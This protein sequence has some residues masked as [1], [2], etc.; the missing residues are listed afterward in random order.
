MAVTMAVY[1]RMSGMLQESLCTV[2]GV[3]QRGWTMLRSNFDWRNSAGIKREE[4]EVSNQEKRGECRGEESIE[5]ES[6]ERIRGWRGIRRK[7]AIKGKADAEYA[8]D[9]T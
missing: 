7:G 3:E 8:V 4:G 5:K 6:G 2:Y 9:M 1:L